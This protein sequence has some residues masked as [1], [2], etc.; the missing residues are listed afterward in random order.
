VRGKKRI[1]GEKKEAWL[2]GGK[3]TC[4]ICVTL[5]P[6]RN[7][8][9]FTLR[10]AKRRL[11][12]SRRAGERAIV[13]PRKRCAK[14]QKAGEAPGG[15]ENGALPSDFQKKKKIPEETLGTRSRCNLWVGGKPGF[16][17]KP[18][19]AEYC[20]RPYGAADFQRTA[21]T[22]RNIERRRK[23]THSPRRKCMTKGESEPPDLS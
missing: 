5:P 4:R 13:R 12:F 16:R 11:D 8:S 17:G 21:S 1:L 22:A 6:G 18:T 7:K 3:G 10:E 20:S 19:L 15:G 2:T 9:R 23:S 14:R